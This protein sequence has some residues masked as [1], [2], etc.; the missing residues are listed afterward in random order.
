MRYLTRKST[1]IGPY[2]Y[3]VYGRKKEVDVH[4]VREN[5]IGALKKQI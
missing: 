2:M 1:R 3:V 5:D 4:T